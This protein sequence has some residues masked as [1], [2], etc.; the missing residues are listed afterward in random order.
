GFDP[1]GDSAGISKSLIAARVRPASWTLPVIGPTWSW[2]HD[3]GMTPSAGTR[4]YVGLSPTMPHSAAGVRIE[5]A[6]SVPNA[7]GQMPAAT[8]AADPLLDP[9]VMCSGLRGLRGGPKK[10]TSPVPP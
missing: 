5:Q 6:V 3:N 10:E 1:A 2:L 4:P 8:A 7:T 9:P